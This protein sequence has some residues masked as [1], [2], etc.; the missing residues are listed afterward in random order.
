MGVLPHEAPR[1]ILR[2]II[3]AVQRA[4]IA[5]YRH[6]RRAS[7]FSAV[8]PYI[9]H[10][11]AFDKH[12]S[13]FL[14]SRHCNAAIGQRYTKRRQPTILHKCIYNG[15]SFTTRR[16]MVGASTGHMPPSLATS[17]K[18]SHGRHKM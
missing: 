18:D 5:A 10:S 3:A 4:F 2:A 12:R 1:M 11:L 8:L 13:G 6:T 7:I 14:P 15:R 16:E 9:A 17:L